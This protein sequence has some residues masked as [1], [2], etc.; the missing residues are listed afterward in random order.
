MYKKETRGISKHLDFLVMDVLCLQLALLMSYGAANGIQ[1]LYTDGL[2]RN[3]AVFFA[4]LD[5]VVMI[6]NNTLKNVLKRGY[7][8]EFRTT[9]KHVI[10]MLSVCAIG[11]MGLKIGAHYSRKIFFGTFGIYL[12]LSY[13]TRV[14]RKFQLSRKSELEGDRSLLIVADKAHVE[15]VIENIRQYSFG[16]FRFA[17]LVILDEDMTGQEFGGIKV[18]TN[19][20]EA[21]NY[22]CKEWIDEVMVMPNEE[23]QTSQRLLEQRMKTGVTVHMNLAKISKE[24]G[25]KQIVEKIGDY[26]VLTTSMNTATTMQIVIK[27]AMDIAGGLLGCLLTGILLLFVGPA[28]Y[29]ASPGP[30]FFAQ[31]RVGKNG[32]LF[33]MYKF[34]S[35]YPDAEKRK[36]ELMKQ[37]KV[38]DAKMFK[39]DFDPRVI[40]NRILPDGRQKTGIGQFIRKTSIDEFPQFFNVLKGDM[41]IVGTRPPLISEVSLYDLH[42]RTRLAIKPG[43][44]GMWQVSGR[45]DIT[46]FEEVVKLDQEYINNW[47]LGLDIKILLKTILV[48]F[49]KDGSM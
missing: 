10:Y 40:G 5:I 29:I 39:M 1:N 24:P 23:S 41:S 42:H 19:V 16:R 7:Y 26:T 47:N 34:R 14:I 32:K 33:K 3:L 31:E 20:L 25:K 46:E 8:V 38:S 35:M 48:V 22:V 43:I 27:R 13:A 11:M 4:L 15:E 18:V 9:L 28:I 37:N 12:L 21:A 49:R 30:I 44:T 17:G 36:A 45:S 6:L 2:Y